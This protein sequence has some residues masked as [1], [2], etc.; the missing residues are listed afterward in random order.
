MVSKSSFQLTR[1]V[2]LLTF[3]NV[4]CQFTTDQAM[5][6]DV[7][8]PNPQNTE[9]VT[10][11]VS[12]YE[13]ESFR[14]WP[15]RTEHNFRTFFRSKNTSFRKTS[16][17]SPRLRVSGRNDETDTVRPVWAPADGMAWCFEARDESSVRGPAS[18]RL[19]F[20]SSPAYAVS[21]CASL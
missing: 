8:T 19:R 1:E 9:S 21:L 17:G 12:P 20:P 13:T 14:F 4:T 7:C 2:A 18:R 6:L 15:F 5:D 11:R 3:R 16:W 10:E